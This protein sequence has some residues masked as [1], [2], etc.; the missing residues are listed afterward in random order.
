L[1][2]L[3]ASVRSQ[4]ENK[5]KLVLSKE[6]GGRWALEHLAPQWHPVIQAALQNYRSDRP[7][8]TISLAETQAFYHAFV[9]EL[10]QS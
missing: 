7:E 1:V 4:V 6:E 5:E 8:I 2:S 10:A 3:S 9:N